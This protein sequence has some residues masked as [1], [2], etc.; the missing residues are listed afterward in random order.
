MASDLLGDEWEGDGFNAPKIYDLYNIGR[1][2]SEIG[3]ALNGS[4]GAFE[5]T[6]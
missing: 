2:I 5:M 3:S 4:T 6:N 1:D